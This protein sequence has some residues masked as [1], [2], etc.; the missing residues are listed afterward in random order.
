MHL[1]EGSVDA[2][3]G[4]VW[5][6]IADV[7]PPPFQPP[8]S[9]GSTTKPSCNGSTACGYVTARSSVCE[10]GGGNCSSISNIR[11]ALG[12]K[13]T[14]NGRDASLSSNSV[15][16]RLFPRTSKKRFDVLL[17]GEVKS[18]TEEAVSAAGN[19]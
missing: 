8:P 10:N 19:V 5:R 6:V 4:V 1:N 13:L 14:T 16:R 17:D 2:A 15:V 9:T 12:K 18:N 11:N 7:S 3:R